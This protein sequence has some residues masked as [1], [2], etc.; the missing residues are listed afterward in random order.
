MKIRMITIR[1]CGHKVGL[2]AYSSVEIPSLEATVELEDGDDPLQVYRRLKKSFDAAVEDERRAAIERWGGD[3]LQAR[4]P[5]V[6]HTGPNPAPRDVETA[7]MKPL[8]H[9]P[10][11]V[12]PDYPQGDAMVVKNRRCSD[13]SHP[14]RQPRYIT[15]AEWNYSINLFGSPLCRNHQAMARRQQA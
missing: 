6:G 2:P 9:G 12:H 10:S 4:T 1:S 11:H 14:A 8:A 15:A 7:P 3:G 13:A 5:P